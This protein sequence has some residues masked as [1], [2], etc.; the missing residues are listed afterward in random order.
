MSIKEYRRTASAKKFQIRKRFPGMDGGTTQT[1]P[2]LAHSL[3]VSDTCWQKKIIV[4]LMEN[5]TSLDMS[6]DT[7]LGSCSGSS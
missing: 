2:T 7:S 6:H 5:G 4:S 3:L 1:L